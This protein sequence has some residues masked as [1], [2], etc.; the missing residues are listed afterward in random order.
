MAYVAPEIK[1]TMNLIN[2]FGAVSMEQLVALSGNSYPKASGIIRF[3][4]KGNA[5][6]LIDEKVLVERKTKTY[7]KSD[8]NN[9]WVI[10]DMLSATLTDVNDPILCS[11]TLKSL[12]DAKD[13][14]AEVSFITGHKNINYLLAV[15][16]NKLDILNIV[17]RNLLK[18]K[19]TENNNDDNINLIFVTD[20]EN[21]V[22][23]IAERKFNF[24]YTIAYVKN[25]EEG[26]P[27]IEYYQLG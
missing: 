26:K 9:L 21:V 27:E 7:K 13:I 24:K 15:A 1:E 17:D 25:T 14:G 2:C 11:N 18:K 20:K 19:K 16:E 22:N 4:C 23:A 3:L 8:L 5:C 12:I 6:S 10:I